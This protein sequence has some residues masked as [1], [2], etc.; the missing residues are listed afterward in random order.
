MQTIT[1]MQ[2]DNSV[3]YYMEKRLDRYK[4]NTWR[5]AKSLTT[6]EWWDLMK[7]GPITKEAIFGTKKFKN[8]FLQAIKNFTPGSLK[9][10]V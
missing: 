10:R 6:D 3:S 5:F 4:I 2:F 9:D 8:Y 7:D 1:Q